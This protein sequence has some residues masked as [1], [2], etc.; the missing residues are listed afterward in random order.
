M[1]KF[2]K[3][4]WDFK[5]ENKQTEV[6]V[7]ELT[8]KVLSFFLVVSKLKQIVKWSGRPTASLN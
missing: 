7:Q 6:D 5:F 4:L 8:S 1:L 2:R 3:F